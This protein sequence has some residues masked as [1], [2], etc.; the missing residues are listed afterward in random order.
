MEMTYFRNIFHQ[1]VFF[2]S[3]NTKM[4]ESRKLVLTY[5]SLYAYFVKC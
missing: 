3:A 5:R 4:T 2:R 1:Q